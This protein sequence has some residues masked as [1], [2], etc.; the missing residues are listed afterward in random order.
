MDYLFDLARNERLVADI[1]A[2]LAAARAEAK[3]RRELPTLLHDP[4]DEQEFI[5]L[6]G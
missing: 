1:A 3:P 5:S 4:G 6:R 2:K